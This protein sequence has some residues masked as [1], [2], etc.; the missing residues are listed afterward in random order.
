MEMF[1]YLPAIS[2]K[3]CFSCPFRRHKG[4]NVSKHFLFAFLFTICSPF[5][6]FLYFKWEIE[7]YSIHLLYFYFFTL[8]FSNYN[9]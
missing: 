4:D 7:F 6:L 1:Y 5:F 3:E 2:Y 9:L 8:G